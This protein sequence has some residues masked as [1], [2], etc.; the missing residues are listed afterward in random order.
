MFCSSNAFLINTAR[1]KIV[2]EA[3]LVNAL[4]KNVI[5]GA[6]LDVFTHEPPSMGDQV[7][8]CPSL[9]LTPHTG[10]ASEDVARH[11]SIEVA[12][13][14]IAILRGQKPRYLVNPD[15]VNHLY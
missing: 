10:S 15:Y 1:G 9:A 7:F 8:S 13:V 2:D 14:V 12:E 5:A 11:M 4:R 3:A 6:A